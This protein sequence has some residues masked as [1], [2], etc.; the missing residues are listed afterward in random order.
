MQQFRTHRARV[1]TRRDA[2][3]LIAAAFIAAALA[4]S[5]PL[6]ARAQQSGSQSPHAQLPESIAPA[7]RSIIE[8]L[9][10]SL[11]ADG[12]PDSP[13]YSKAAEGV[14]KQASDE[15]IVRAVRSL[16]GELRGAH[17]ALG[18][19]ADPAELVAGASA[20]HAG[21]T[22]RELRRMHARQP[23]N[24]AGSLAVPLTVLADLITR[25]VPADAATASVDALLDRHVADSEFLQLRVGIERDI[26]AGDA[27]GAAA[28]EWTRR[29]L[30]NPEL[31]GRRD[32]PRDSPRRRIP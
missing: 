27:P 9:A 7:A 22:A 23:R 31:T 30:A 13:L 32:V 15:R 3:A 12:I 21:L 28:Q 24:A 6:A 14:L 4:I 29:I 26:S 25:G 18:A 10:D 8:L 11:R 16:A 17:A 1:V 5:S 20:L 19:G 2:A